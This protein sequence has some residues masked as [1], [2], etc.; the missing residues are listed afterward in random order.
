MVVDVPND[1]CRVSHFGNPPHSALVMNKVW[2]G[3][4]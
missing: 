4:C 3:V 1:V 2:A